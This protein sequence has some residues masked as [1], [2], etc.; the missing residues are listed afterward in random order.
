MSTAIYKTRWR[1]CRGFGLISASGLE[2][3]VITD[4]T[5]NAQTYRQVLINPALPSAEHLIDNNF[6]FKHESISTYR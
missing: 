1:L 3:A 5:M 4:G 2:D 6:I